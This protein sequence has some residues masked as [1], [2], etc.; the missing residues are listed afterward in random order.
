MKLIKQIALT[1]TAMMMVFVLGACSSH[2]AQEE[3]LNNL[4]L[5]YQG[6]QD[7][8]E[9]IYSIANF[10]DFS[11]HPV[12]GDSKIKTG[13]TVHFALDPE[14]NLTLSLKVLKDGVVIY[15][16]DTSI[17]L[18]N[19]KKVTVAIVDSANGSL[20]AKVTTK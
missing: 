1:V 16:G 9:I 18:S 6:N 4:K 10:K 8:D 13:H 20:E 7:I 2:N 14:N 19:G 11:T 15:E 5:I 17:D 12:G 3:E